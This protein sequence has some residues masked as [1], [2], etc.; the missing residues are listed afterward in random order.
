M[1]ITS[2]ASINKVICSYTVEIIYFRSQGEKNVCSL[3]IGDT[4]DLARG[5]T[6][7][8]DV[9]VVRSSVLEVR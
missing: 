8:Q 6:N 7:L 4:R 2:L 5:S 3:P 1:L 9:G